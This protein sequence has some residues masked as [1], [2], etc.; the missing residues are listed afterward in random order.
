MYEEVNSWSDVANIW[1]KM[2]DL[3]V[4]KRCI[5]SSWIK[6]NKEIHIFAVSDKHHPSYG[7]FHLLLVELDEH[8]RLAG[9][10]PEL[11]SILR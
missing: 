8:L 11:G 9:Y 5:G 10:V 6:I 7:R 3:S 2:K 1:T 4:E